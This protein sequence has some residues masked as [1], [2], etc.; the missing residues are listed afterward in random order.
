MVLVRDRRDDGA[1][2][3][4]RHMTGDH[5]EHDRRRGNDRGEGQLADRTVIRIVLCR[6]M[7]IFMRL[8]WAS[9]VV[10]AR[11]RGP[12]NRGRQEHAKRKHGHK[13]DIAQL[14]HKR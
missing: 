10:F 5:G 2:R 7:M 9:V 6:R 4:F 14:L 12:V 13:G 3:I 11:T 8:G 1:V